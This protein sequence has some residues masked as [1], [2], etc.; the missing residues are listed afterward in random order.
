MKKDPKAGEIVRKETKRRLKYAFTDKEKLEIAT[1]LSR[2]LQA[3][4]SFEDELKDVKAQYKSKIESAQA[5]INILQGHIYSGHEFRMIDC[6]DE[7]HYDQ[8]KVYTVRLD[9][10]ET[11][12]TRHMTEWEL[13]QNFLEE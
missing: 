6:V 10:G 11:V 8:R 1:E 9:T 3:L 12:E 7:R 4:R 13:Q 2:E 5:K